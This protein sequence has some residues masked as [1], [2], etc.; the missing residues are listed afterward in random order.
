MKLYVTETSPYARMARIMVLEKGLEDRVEVL[1][2]RTR[3]AGSP[4]YEINPSGRVPYL[5]CDDDWRLE[6]S[7][8][9]CAH[10]DH[11]DG[12]PS[13][14]PPPGRDGWEVRRLEGHAR[15]LMDGLSVWGR[16]LIR[17]EEDRS[18]T[19]IAHEQER[20]RRLVDF[21]EGEIETPLLAEPFRNMAQL[22]LAVALEL[23]ARLPGFDWRADHPK[24]AAWLD[25]FT[26][27]PSFAATLP[28]AGK[29]G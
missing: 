5:I 27:R 17:P 9:I 13:F 7:Q 11:L 22:T 26:Q 8:L 23:D 28:G 4:Y 20:A 3:Q 1:M 19:I 24:L 21:W 12:P 10:F 16:E 15:S 29:Q 14:E 25:P 2:A 18:A 6:E